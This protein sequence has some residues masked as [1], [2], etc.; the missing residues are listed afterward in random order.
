MPSMQHHDAVGVGAALGRAISLLR[1]QLGDATAAV[2]VVTPSSVNGTLARRELA[3]S[4]SFIRVSFVTA[5]Q[6][7]LTLA[8]SR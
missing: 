2:A 8:L 1:E 3:R 5:A 4:E 7:H 6:L